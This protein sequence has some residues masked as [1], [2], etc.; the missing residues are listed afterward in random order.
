MCRLDCGLGDRSLR[1]ERPVPGR[2]S[3]LDHHDL[4][5]ERADLLDLGVRPVRVLP[6][7]NHRALWPGDHTTW[8]AHSLLVK[9]VRQA[10]GGRE[11]LVRR[12]HRTLAVPV[13]AQ[14]LECDQLRDGWFPGAGVLALRCAILDI[15]S[16]G[17][18][19]RSAVSRA[20]FLEPHFS[21]DGARKDGWH[22]AF[23]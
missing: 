14:L 9:R 20:G 1:G 11:L 8:R 2:L 5:V 16:W 15:V 3:W 10:D 12:R 18:S 22:E 7:K 6:F 19:R 13:V 17:G 23:S 21:P 4:G